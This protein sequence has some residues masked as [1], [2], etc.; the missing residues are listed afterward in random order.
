MVVLV[1][2]G[3]PGSGNV[4]QSQMD[5][6][7]V[8][9]GGG[10]GGYK[11]IVLAPASVQETH[12][13]M[14][15]AF[16][17]ADKYRNLV[18]VLSEALTGLIAEPLELKTLDFGPLPEKDWAITGTGQRKD[19]T[20]RGI[21][22]SAPHG[23]T[24]VPYLVRIREKFKTMESEVRY[25]EYK[26]DDAELIIV[27]FGYVARVSKDAVNTARE[28]GIKVGLLR[29]ITLWPFPHQKI[30]EKAAQGCKFLVVEDNLGQMVEDVKIA[31]E[32]KTP[33]YLADVTCRHLS[34][35]YGII[36]P[37][38]VL[39]KIKESL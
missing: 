17:L 13:L 3:G 18:I 31:V 26:T 33:V 2:R 38:K 37:A 30:R 14:Q 34:S 1:Q 8:T 6:D 7:S 24:Y 28:Q 36:M 10:G 39:E 22:G 23:P 4:R 16:Y 15:L 29:P 9:K 5:Y 11:N 35:E 32:G 25:E 21:S 12:D 27:A 19:G 20:T